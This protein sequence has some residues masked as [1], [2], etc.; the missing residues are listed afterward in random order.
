MRTKLLPLLLLGFVFCA[1]GSSSSASTSLTTSQ[2]AP[3]CKSSI[4]IASTDSTSSTTPGVTPQH[5][6]MG[7]H[8][9]MTAYRPVTANDMARV[10]GIAQNAELCFAKYKDYHLA[11]HD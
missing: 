2:P 3:T 9:K 8:M 1:C 10:E 7:P 11:L 6:H 5:M 4:A